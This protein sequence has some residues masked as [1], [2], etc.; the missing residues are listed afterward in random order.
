M[1]QLSA[2][3][4]QRWRAVG[5]LWLSSCT[6]SPCVLLRVEF[7]PGGVFS[8]DLFSVLHNADSAV[9]CVPAVQVL[10]RGLCPT[11]TRFHGIFGRFDAC[12]SQLRQ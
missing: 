10:R 8:N 11:C 4:V 7:E 2:P 6:L 3:R 9:Q 5:L 1:H 12:S